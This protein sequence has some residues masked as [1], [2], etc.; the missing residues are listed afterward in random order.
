MAFPRFIRTAAATAGLL[1][2]PISQAQ[3][4]PRAP[5]APAAVI[6]P[7]PPPAAGATSVPDA[8]RRLVKSRDGRFNGEM[9]GMASPGSRFA[10]L[11]IGM[12][13]LEVNQLIGAPAQLTGHETGKRWIPFYYGNDARRLQ[14]LYTG[15]GCL[16][17][18]GGNIWG[19]GGNELI[20]IWADPSGACWKP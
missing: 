16:T 17:F 9:I 3:E 6:V 11:Q 20:R 13:S 7:A 4:P 18:T 5:D 8:G 19:G 2:G 15:E 1:A 14:V 10:Q 12:S